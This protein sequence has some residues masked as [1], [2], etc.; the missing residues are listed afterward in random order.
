MRQTPNEKPSGKTADTAYDPCDFFEMD[1]AAQ[2]TPLFDQHPAIATYLSVVLISALL[3][4][5]ELRIG[6]LRPF[7]IFVAGVGLL[8]LLRVW[9]LPLILF[10]VQLE[11]FTSEPVRAV[12]SN[13]FGDVAFVAGVVLLLVAGSRFVVLT[14]SPLPYDTSSLGFFRRIFRGN[15]DTDSGHP[16]RDPD[17]YSATE[18]SAGLIRVTLAVAIA[19]WW[20]WYVPLDPTARDYA[21]LLPESM[22]AITLA[23]WALGVIVLANVLISSYVWQG[24]S[25]GQALVYLHSVVTRWSFSEVRSII[26]RQI[27]ARR[28]RK[29]R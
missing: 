11:L 13:A 28:K 3:L 19:S 8:V 18:L 15:K 12:S 23:V 16:K 2:S 6:V 14:A 1:G 5:T 24:I 27:K 21:W 22:R 29:K 20:M 9:S 26:R 4:L 25:R 7:S 17:L 10:A